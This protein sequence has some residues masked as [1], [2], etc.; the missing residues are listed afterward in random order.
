MGKF[1]GRGLQPLNPSL[2]Y[3]TNRVCKNLNTAKLRTI[4]K[5]PSNLEELHNNVSEYSLITNLGEYFIYK[6]ITMILSTIKLH[7]HAHRTWNNS[8]CSN[9]RLFIDGTFKSCSKQFN[10]YYFLFLLRHTI[11]VFLFFIATP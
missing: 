3:A 7:L 5:L 11:I 9:Y 10:Q 1:R 4:P 8:S 2:G 6:F